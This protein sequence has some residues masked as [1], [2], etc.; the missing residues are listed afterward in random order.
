MVFYKQVLDFH[1][2]S[3]IL[4]QTSGCQDHWSLLGMKR[5]ELYSTSYAIFSVAKFD[6]SIGGTV[7]LMS[8]SL[9]HQH[10]KSKICLFK[11]S[12]S[13]ILRSSSFSDLIVNKNISLFIPGF[14]GSKIF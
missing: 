3:K 4:C 5:S 2:P 8:D 14:M 11:K 9:S 1:R 13:K 12:I 6:M 10:K 7:F